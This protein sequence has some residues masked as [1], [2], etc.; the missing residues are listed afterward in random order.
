[1]A[2][3]LALHQQGELVSG[4]NPLLGDAQVAKAGE[5]QQGAT[6]RQAAQ[7]ERAQGGRGGE[8]LVGRIG[9]ILG[10]VEQRLLVEAKGRGERGFR[11]GVGQSQPLA[12]VGEGAGG[13]Q[14]RRGEDHWPRVMVEAGAQQRRHVHRRGPQGHVARGERDPA[15]RIAAR[16]AR[17]LAKI[18]AQV[19]RPRRKPGQHG[20]LGRRG[21]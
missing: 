13:R 6:A 2:R 4:S 14:R 7:V 20:G 12:H 10:D 15:H 5:E 8:A 17:D 16:G 9:Q 21:R 11:R 19:V 1:M 3:A 18:R